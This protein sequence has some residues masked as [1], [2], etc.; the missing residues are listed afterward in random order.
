[1]YDEGHGGQVI[2]RV[3]QNLLVS[4]KLSEPECI[5]LVSPLPS[6]LNPDP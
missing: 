4:S 3:L 1:M 2:P 6:T 5:N